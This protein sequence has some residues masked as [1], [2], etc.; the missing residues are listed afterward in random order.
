M[1]RWGLCWSI[2][3]QTGASGTVPGFVS[4]PVWLPGLPSLAGR[5]TGS[6]GSAGSAPGA[7]GWSKWCGVS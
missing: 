5:G 7:A 4:G 3:E 1:C 6:A 2:K